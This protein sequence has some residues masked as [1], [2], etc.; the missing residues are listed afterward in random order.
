MLI[1][2]GD[3]Q[4]VRHVTLRT[5]GSRTSAC[6]LLLRRTIRDQFRGIHPTENR[7]VD[8]SVSNFSLQLLALPEE[9]QRRAHFLQAGVA[10][11]SN[12]MRAPPLYSI[13]V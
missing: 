1:L 5:R 4:D 6:G 11:E 9:Q 8:F 2:V 7:L 3:Q 13:K 10:G 12:T